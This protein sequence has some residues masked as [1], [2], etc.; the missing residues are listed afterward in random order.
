MPVRG[1]S[2]VRVTQGPGN[3]GVESPDGEAFYYNEAWDRPSAVFRLSA[4]GAAVT[5]LDR[6]VLGQFAVAD[7]GIYYMDRATRTPGALATDR[8]GPTSLQYFDFATRTSRTLVPDLGTVGL[9]MTIS[10]D[11]RTIL[12]ARVDASVD[13]LMLVEHFR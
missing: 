5:L 13:D 3:S 1:G 7:R 4:G 8:P 2:A 11:G 12:Y 6:V 10:R 9:G